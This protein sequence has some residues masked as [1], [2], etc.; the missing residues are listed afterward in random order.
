VVPASEIIHDTM[1]PLF[2]P[3]CGV[4]PLF[5]CGLAAMQGIT[6]QNNSVAFFSNGAT[7]SGILTAPGEISDPDAERFKKEWEVKFTGQNAG[8]VAVLGGG[9]KY[10]KMTMSAEESQMIEQ[11]KW[12]A[13]TVCSC[14]HLPAYMVGVGTP[15]AYNN[16][17]ALN[18]Q[19]YSQCLQALIESIE[20]LLDEGLGLTEVKGK[21][22]G[23]EFDLDDLLR[24]DTATQID[25]LAKAVGGSIMPPNVALRKQ[26]IAPVAGGDTIYMQQQNYS[27]E[28]LMPAAAPAAALLQTTPHRSTTPPRPRS[29]RGN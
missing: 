8:R 10:E 26:N 20:L 28:A 25:A 18:Q 11:L 19:Y 15:P 4:S 2:H 27:L 21:T 3:L 13:E 14:F 12:T 22:Y 1:V 5:A 6:I 16:V 29:S 7:P 24:M 17:E 9:L 23:T